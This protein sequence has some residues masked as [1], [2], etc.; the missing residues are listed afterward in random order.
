MSRESGERRSK[1]R[2]LIDEVAHGALPRGSDTVKKARWGLAMWAEKL[3]LQIYINS[4]C[5]RSFAWIPQGE[6]R[7]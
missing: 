2:R 3:A 1:E 5:K 6:L 7:C 4:R